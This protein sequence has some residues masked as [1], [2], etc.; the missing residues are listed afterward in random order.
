MTTDIDVL[1]V[2]QLG[3]F[4]CNIEEDHRD[5][6]APALDFLFQGF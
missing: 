2:G 5:D 1:V 3:A 4:V 6:I